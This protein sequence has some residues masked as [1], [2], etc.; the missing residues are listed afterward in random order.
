MNFWVV[1]FVGTTIASTYMWMRE[2]REHANDLEVYSA[3]FKELSRRIEE[4]NECIEKLRW[5]PEQ[6]QEILDEVRRRLKEGQ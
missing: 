3:R 1:L 4:Y 2:C 6:Y 5:T